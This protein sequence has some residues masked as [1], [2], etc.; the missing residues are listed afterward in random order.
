MLLF[1]CLVIGLFLC[2]DIQE[3]Y[4]VT[5]SLNSMQNRRAA[6]Q[7]DHEPDAE[8]KVILNKLRV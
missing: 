3:C 5:L 8:N 2:A 6:G 4:E 1:L 7:E